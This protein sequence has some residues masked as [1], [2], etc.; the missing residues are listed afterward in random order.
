MDHSNP[1]EQ[2]TLKKRSPSVLKAIPFDNRSNAVKGNPHDDQATIKKKNKLSFS[3]SSPHEEVTIKKRDNW[4]SPEPSTGESN[5]SLLLQ[6]HQHEDDE[7]ERPLE[8][9]EIDDDILNENSDFQHEIFQN[10]VPAKEIMAKKSRSSR[11]SGVGSYFKAARREG[12]GGSYVPKGFAEEAMESNPGESAS[13]KPSTVNRGEWV[14]VS[15]KN[16]TPQRV[17]DTRSDFKSMPSRNTNFRST[18]DRF[19]KSYIKPHFGTG[20]HI[21]AHT[22]KTE[23]LSTVGAIDI[24]V[25]DPIGC[26]SLIISVLFVRTVGCV[27]MS[28]KGERH[29]R[30]SNAGSIY[31]NGAGQGKGIGLAHRRTS[32]HA[33]FANAV[34]EPSAAFKAPSHHRAPT[35]TAWMKN[36]DAEERSEQGLMT[37]PSYFDQ[38]K[39]DKSHSAFMTETDRF[40]GHSSYVQA[41]AG[42]GAKSLGMAHED[43]EQRVEKIGGFRMGH[44]RRH[45]RFSNVHSIFQKAAANEAVEGIGL[46]HLTLGDKGVKAATPSAA[47]L[48]QKKNTSSWLGADGADEFASLPEDRTTFDSSKMS[49]AIKFDLST[50]ERFKGQDSHFAVPKHT[51]KHIGGTMHDGIAQQVARKPGGG[52]VRMVK[53][54]RSRFSM[55]GGI[56]QRKLVNSSVG[57]SHNQHQLSIAKTKGPGTKSPAFA[58]GSKV[59]SRSRAGWLQ[60]QIGSR[61]E[62]APRPPNASRSSTS[63]LSESSCQETHVNI[64]INPV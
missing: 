2:A 23:E 50:S 15:N 41:S 32:I 10:Q 20:H 49:N 39:L 57:L 22:D 36:K 18:E 46:T 11:F 26:V 34:S 29:R 53:S 43:M 12:D 21:L 51:S 8:G 1:T 64:T 30:F 44:A 59:V 25:T 33:I 54:R 9:E 61:S 13:F 28:P 19:Q 6:G 47:F 62:R 45:G 40:E 63:P 4:V 48:G 3:V 16:V 58:L 35:R 55:A 5:F 60:A 31:K 17:G 52:G 14:D 56:H 42:E 38:T 7:V 24:D 27:S 37:A